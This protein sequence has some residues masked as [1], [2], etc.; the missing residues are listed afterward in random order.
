M[1]PKAAL[2]PVPLPRCDDLLLP[3]ESI[4]NILYVP[5]TQTRWVLCRVRSDER[6][7]RYEGFLHREEE[8]AAIMALAKDGLL[9]P[10]SGDVSGRSVFVE[11]CALYRSGPR[12]GVDVRAA[13][14]RQRRIP[15]TRS[16]ARLWQLRV[17]KC[18]R[19]KRL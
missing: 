3:D 5:G 7:R 19:M 9:A 18:R 14:F 11:V 15:S 10:N 16:I 4:D 6:R 2:R 12:A 8:N 13:D 1:L 17:I